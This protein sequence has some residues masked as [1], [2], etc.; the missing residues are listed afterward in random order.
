MWNLGVWIIKTHAESFNEFCGID[1]L[2]PWWLE[3]LGFQFHVDS[4]I[5]D[6]CFDFIRDERQVFWL[7]KLEHS[8]DTGAVRGTTK[9]AEV[10]G[11]QW[12]NEP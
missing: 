11:R 8:G 1:Y 4:R 6:R 9:V 12:S 10:R 5:R 2:S 3:K 7:N